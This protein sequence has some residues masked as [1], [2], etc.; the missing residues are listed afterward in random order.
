MGLADLGWAHTGMCD[1][2]AGWLGT[3][4]LWAATAGHLGSPPCVPHILQQVAWTQAH[5]EM[6]TPSDTSASG[7]SGVGWQYPNLCLCHICKHPVG[8][9]KPHGRGRFRVGGDHTVTGQ[10]CEAINFRPLESPVSH[11][12]LNSPRPLSLRM[13][14]PKC[15]GCILPPAWGSSRPGMGEARHKGLVQGRASAV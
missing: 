14:A 6:G 11:I 5:G 2:L 8:Q 12:E 7:A 9:R 10:V 13:G 1:Q 4:W 15:P 3:G